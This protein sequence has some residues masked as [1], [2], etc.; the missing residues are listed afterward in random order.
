MNYYDIFISYRRNGGFETAKHLYDL[1]TRD[2]YQ[3][4]F[5]ID[6]LRSGNFNTELLHRIDLCTDFIVVLDKHA[7]NRS[8][9]TT[10]NRDQDW[11]R[12][13]L[14]YALKQK[15]NIIPVI[16]AGF[17]DFPY[18]LPSDIEEIRYKNGP[19]YDQYYFDAFYSRLTEFLISQP[20]NRSNN[21]VSSN[22][23]T[24]DSVL[25]IETDLICRI[26]VD[27]KERCTAK[28]DT[29][30]RIL[31][32]EGSYCLRFV[33]IDNQADFIEDKKFRIKKNT[34]EL[35]IVSLLPIR[36]NRETR[37]AHE[38]YLMQLNDNIFKVKI[39]DQNGKAGYVHRHTNEIL[40]PLAYED[41]YPFK[42]GYAW[43]KKN[44]K[45]ELI[46]HTGAK[47]TQDSY[48]DIN[49]SEH[50][51]RVKKDGKWGFI[52]LEGIEVIPCI[53]DEARDFHVTNMSNREAL[54][55]I[56]ASVKKDGKWKFIDKLGNDISLNTYEVTHDFNCGRA[57]VRKN[58]KWGFID[59][60]GIE[61]IPCIYNEASNFEF[62]LR[63]DSLVANSKYYSRYIRARVRKDGKWKFIDE[64]GNSLSIDTYEEA[65]GFHYGRARVRKN[66]KWGF[67]D[68]S[69][70]EVIPC[71]YNKATDFSNKFIISAAVKKNILGKLGY[72]KEIE[73]DGTKFGKSSLFRPIG[74]S[75]K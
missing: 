4:S 31:L 59:L 37:E 45:Y 20:I 6:T 17:T 67:I 68:Y 15:K 2:G 74:Y 58:G 71:V 64:S 52:D 10:F 27:G 33:S 48:E 50:R 30:T 9:D 46:N 29:V 62:P 49:L 66:G 56:R 32:R 38:H 47:V 25:K 35:Y 24:S 8:V 22:S 69:G 41:C 51:T 73:L 65:Y 44:G 40:L 23:D 55:Y 34:E 28:P 61:V 39:S 11:L 19:K 26:L 54:R 36:K 42:F 3:V 63:K 60:E 16:L 43:V 21:F 75:Y 1:L 72:W 14:A 5:D 53:Y 18:N 70:K 13:E 57:R 12:I 7:F